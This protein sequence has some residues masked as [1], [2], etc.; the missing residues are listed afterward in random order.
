MPVVCEPEELLLDQLGA[1]PEQRVGQFE[2]QGHE[3]IEGRPGESLPSSM[4]S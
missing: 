4:V 2:E 3:D 1:L